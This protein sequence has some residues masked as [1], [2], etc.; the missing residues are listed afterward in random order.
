MLYLGAVADWEHILTFKKDAHYGLKGQE[1]SSDRLGFG[2]R[3]KNIK[4]KISLSK[5]R[6]WWLTEKFARAKIDPKLAQ[7]DFYVVMNLGDAKSD[8]SDDL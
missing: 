3:L 2:S 1:D 4:L 6:V 8:W 7:K 5:I